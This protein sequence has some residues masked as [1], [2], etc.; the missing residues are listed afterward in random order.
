MLGVGTAQVT[1]QDVEA[2]GREL[3]GARPPIEYYQFV[4]TNPNAF[5]FS[6]DNGWIR[7]ARAV[8]AQRGAARG[9]ASLE[10]VQPAAFANGV[11]TGDLN[12]PVFLVLY[13]NT[14]SATVVTIFDPHLLSG[15]LRGPTSRKRYCVRLDAGLRE[16][17][18]L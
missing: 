16:R 14:D 1:A 8:A 11:L 6:P 13:A 12:V 9:L 17:L 2:L 10:S 15:D 18:A 5:R 4:A 3:G 7:R